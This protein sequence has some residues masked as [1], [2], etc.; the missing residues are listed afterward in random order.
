ME[1]IILTQD[2]QEIIDSFRKIPPEVQAAFIKL[3]G[4]FGNK[5]Q[6][7]DALENLERVTGNKNL[8]QMVREQMPE[9]LTA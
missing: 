2:E 8:V 1:E 4:A 9:E 6:M 3:V 7:E 5:E